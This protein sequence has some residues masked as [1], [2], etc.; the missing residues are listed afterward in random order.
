MLGILRAVV[1]S[2]SCEKYSKIMEHLPSHE[3][4]D[5]VFAQENPRRKVVKLW[6]QES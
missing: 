2:P 4:V 3:K 5:G 6:P 1:A